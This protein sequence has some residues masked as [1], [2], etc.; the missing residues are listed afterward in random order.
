MKP[1]DSNRA[2]CIVCKRR[3]NQD[4]SFFVPDPNTDG[5]TVAIH[6]S[7]GKNLVCFRCGG[8]GESLSLNPKTGEG[9]HGSRCTSDICPVCDVVIADSKYIAIDQKK[10]HTEC[11]PKSCSVC[12]TSMNHDTGT[13]VQCPGG[14]KHLSCPEAYQKCA[15]CS[16]PVGDGWVL[17]SANIWHPSCLAS[18]YNANNNCIVCNQS[19]EFGLLRRRPTAYPEI[20]IPVHHACLTGSRCPNCGEPGCGGIQLNP[21]RALVCQHE[22]P[23]IRDLCRFCEKVIGPT[24]FSSLNDGKYHHDECMMRNACSVCKKQL[25]SADVIVDV[26]GFRHSACAFVTCAHCD[27]QFPNIE[28]RVVCDKP[29]HRGCAPRCYICKGD[30]DPLIVGSDGQFRHSTC[31][32]DTCP[33]CTICLGNESEVA[34]H[35]EKRFHKTCLFAC[36]RCGTTNFRYSKYPQDPYI[37]SKNF[38]FLD[39]AVK[40]RCILFYGIMRKLS[41]RTGELDRQKLPTDI[42]KLLL[43][44]YTSVQDSS[45]LR[46]SELPFTKR[47][48]VDLRDYCSPSQ[49]SQLKCRG[50][51]G[52]PW[53]SSHFCG[54]MPC[55]LIRD[56]QVKIICEVYGKPRQTIRNLSFQQGEVMM[57]E[58]FLQFAS[59]L[60]ERQLLLISGY[61]DSIRRIA[62]RQN[63]AV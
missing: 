33:I 18:Y 39:D 46:I 40:K 5:S 35:N 52:R 2:R 27:S 54:E 62:S 6:H 28:G 43:F 58:L 12:H 10:T 26:N 47:G 25:T 30:S 45:L 23:C 13:T 4:D 50:C 49:C 7:C 17:A 8:R 24:K 32:E 53:K 16:N 37:H 57:D 29:Y 60:T 14:F 48:K 61:R 34:A 44:F 56:L 15:R 19:N 42:A 55:K 31:T 21:S 51:G 41:V 22:S 11:L 3:S 20:R 59:S 36:N 9:F 1:S 63:F 38:P